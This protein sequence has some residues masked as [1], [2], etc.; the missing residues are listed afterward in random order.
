MIYELLTIYDNKARAFLPPFTCTHLDIGLRAVREALRTPGHQFNKWP[1][2][3]HLY[4]VGK[5]NDETAGVAM[6]QQPINLGLV[7]TLEA[8]DQAVAQ[9]EVQP[10]TKE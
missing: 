6:F 7:G 2:D 4:H 10:T 5:W 9:L 8:K 3:F 1:Q